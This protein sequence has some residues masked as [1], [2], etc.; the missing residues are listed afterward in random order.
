MDKGASVASIGK[1][2][3]ENPAISAKLIQIANSAFFNL[4]KNDVAKVEEAIVRLGLDLVSD[5]I[6]IAELYTDIEPL[7]G[8]NLEQAFSNS[9]RVALLARELVTEQDKGMTN[10]AGL[11]HNIGQYVMCHLAPEK[12][13]QYI[14]E[15]RHATDILALESTLFH[16]TNYQLA[17]Y[18]LH[19]WNFPYQV[20][21]AILFAQS[22]DDML[23][24]SN[25]SV[26]PCV[27]IYIAISLLENTSIDPEVI[28]YFNLKDNIDALKNNQVSSV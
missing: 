1:K 4:G 22:P 12:V 3:N 17:A 20:V 23:S 19:L 11:L 10:L 27:A 15:K 13:A 25:E 26:P 18:L 14:D 6:V 8:F 16:T 5:I 2:I 28:D 24:F 21:E 7:P 9:L